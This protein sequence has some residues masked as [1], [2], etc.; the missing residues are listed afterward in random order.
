MK[1]IMRVLYFYYDLH[2]NPEQHVLHFESVRRRGVIIIDD[3]DRPLTNADREC[4]RHKVCIAHRGKV[5]VTLYDFR[6]ENDTPLP[7][8]S[9]GVRSFGRL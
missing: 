1:E 2:S 3:D 7:D 6:W 8:D 4:I 9:K 5:L